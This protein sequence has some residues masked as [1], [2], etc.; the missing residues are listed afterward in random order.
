ME[1]TYCIHQPT[2]SPIQLLPMFGAVVYPFYHAIPRD[3]PARTCMRSIQSDRLLHIIHV[4]WLHNI[5][6]LATVSGTPLDPACMI[7]TVLKLPLHEL[8]CQ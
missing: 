7:F 3:R 4:C 8:R 1:D 6:F 2:A 5:I